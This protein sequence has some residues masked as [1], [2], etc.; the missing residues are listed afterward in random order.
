MTTLPNGMT[1]KQRD[2]IEATALT[3][4]ATDGSREEQSDALCAALHRAGFNA[5]VDF[6]GKSAKDAD[7]KDRYEFLKD[8]AWRTM[9]KAVYLANIANDRNG[10]RKVSGAYPDRAKA[11]PNNNRTLTEWSKRIPG[12]LRDMRKAL[13]EWE[14]RKGK[15]AA[16]EAAGK[17]GPKTVTEIVADL[18]KRITTILT[19]ETTDARLEATNVDV[20]M[21]QRAIA[22][23]KK[24]TQDAHEAYVEA[25][26]ESASD[27]P[28]F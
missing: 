2:A 14:I 26:Q 23:F 22:A 20:E 16:P 24:A 8:V 17:S 13:V 21:M 7:R 25:M 18:D 10:N 5:D 19:G 1:E 11:D 9:P 4:G 27:E 28:N 12:K 3:L 15:R 6:Q